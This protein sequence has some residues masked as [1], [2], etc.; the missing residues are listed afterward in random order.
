MFTTLKGSLPQN[1]KLNVCGAIDVMLKNIIKKLSNPLLFYMNEEKYSIFRNFCLVKNTGN[2]YRTSIPK[3]NIGKALEYRFELDKYLKLSYFLITVILYF[4]FIHVKYSLFGLLFFEILWACLISGAR[5]Y[6]SHLYSEYLIRHFGKYEV[7]E[8]NPPVPERK[9]D[10]FVAVFKSKIIV[11]AIVIA[12]LFVPSFFIQ[13]SIKYNLNPKRNNF[14]QAI[15]LS[16]TYFALYPKTAKI[17][18][19]RAYANLRD[20]NYEAALADYK[21]ALNLSGKNIP[22]KI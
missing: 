13:L 12:L 9:Y 1:Y 7:T 11:G 15:K 8:F 20:R 10:E 19:M 2:L 14:K 16:N 22:K 18:D 4:I 5:L 6:C 21:T 3:A 17:Y